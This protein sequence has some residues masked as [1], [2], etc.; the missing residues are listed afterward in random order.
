MAPI[1]LL[2]RNVQTPVQSETMTCTRTTIL[3]LLVASLALTAGCAKSK[4]DRTQGQGRDRLQQT[5]AERVGAIQ[6]N[7]TALARTVSMMPADDPARD[8]KLTLEAL[9]QTSAALAAIEGPNPSGAYRQQL[10]IIESTRSQLQRSAQNVPIEPATD[11]ALRAIYNALMSL[12][13]GRFSGNQA[14]SAGVSE[15]G[16][17]IP[18]LDAVRG[19][20]HS[21]QV[22]DVLSSVA[23]TLQTM[24]DVIEKRLSPP[25]ATRPVA[26]TGG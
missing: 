6:S 3:A 12:R 5:A 15:I 2:D 10:R 26:Q 20:L 14:I 18:Q 17:K 1:S 25:A 8:R 24:T 13:D 19:P 16:Q 4:T 7:V 22:A 23:T 11:S 21:L 9:A